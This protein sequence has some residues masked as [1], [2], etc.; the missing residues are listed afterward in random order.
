VNYGCVECHDATVSDN[1]TISSH[2]NH[3]NGSVQVSIALGGT[4]DGSSTCGTN[5][6]CHS[7]GQA[8]PQYYSTPAWGGGSQLD[9]K[10]CHGRYNT[11]D[12][13]SIAGEPN[14]VGGA[15]GSATANSHKTHVTAAGD[16]AK[17]HDGTT[18]N[19][20]EIKDGSTIHTDGSRDVVIAAAWDTNG[21]TSNYNTGNK[22]CQSVAC[23]G[24]GTPQWGGSLT[25]LSCHGG[26]DG[27]T[28]G[29]GSPNGVGA[30]WSSDGHG[31]TS[32]TVSGDSGPLTSARDGCDYCHD[33]GASHTPTAGTNPYR[34][35]FSATDN[36]LC[37]N[38]HLTGDSGISQ[39]SASGSLTT[40]NGNRNVDTA[41][42]GAK[43]EGTEGG[44]LCWDCHDP[45]G[46]PSNILMIKSLVSKNSDQ[47]GIPGTTVTV[48]FTDNS[49]A[50]QAVGRFTELTNNPATGMCQACHDPSGQG[51]SNPTKYWRSDGTDDEDGPGGNAP[52]PSTH[53]KDTLCTTCHKHTDN[54]K[55]A[56]G[57]DCL[58]AGCH[59]GT[60]I[61]NRRRIDTDFGLQSH[62]VGTGGTNMGGAL[63][64][65]D[66]VVCH[67]EGTVVGGQTDT[68]GQPHMDGVIDLRDADSASAYFSYDKESTANGGMPSS[69]SP[70]LWNSTNAEWRNQTSTQLDPFCLTCHDADGAT[71]TF[72]DGS[73]EG[74]GFTGSALNPFADSKITNEYDELDRTRVVNIMDMVADSGTDYNSDG[75][76]D[77][78]D[79]VFARHAIRGAGMAASHNSVY[80]NIP[81]DGSGP[82]TSLWEDTGNSLVDESVTITGEGPLWNDTS[83]MGC[84]DC[85]TSDGANGSAGNA[86]G[87]NSEYL[88]K[89]ASGTATEGTFAARSYIC[90]KCHV[91]ATY[92]DTHTGGSL[93]ND[94][95]DTTANTGL[96]RSYAN[97][98]D[99][100]YTGIAC[101]NCHGGAPG[102]VGTV[103][104]TSAAEATAKGFG[105]IHGTSS[106]FYN[107]AGGNRESYRF[108]NGGSLRYFDPNGWIPS[109]NSSM[110]CYTLGAGSSSEDQWGG[111]TQHD[112][113]KGAA[114]RLNRPKQ[115]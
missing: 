56:G 50:G 33:L 104:D 107:G 67:A 40:R 34:L 115:Y 108:T 53:N 58:S 36:T 110:S 43:H 17:C 105:R 75:I 103:H 5:T 73:S 98:G 83:V 3:V 78:Y 9:C 102:D 76:T 31:N 30:E 10:G 96:D 62:H 85:H 70:G 7:S 19:G 27:G 46:V 52:V 13:A 100:G 82:Y 114:R 48:N 68:A 81:D 106:V 45:H 80:Q 72:N 2:A 64:N 88:L 95:D 42:F 79:G 1:T 84:A 59:G 55:G 97:K 26:P 101:I 8:T 109:G 20:T 44:K 16:C 32:W 112:R 28:L 14:Y 91:E 111:C 77:P 41:H 21:A 22:T 11:P 29:D 99:G 63:T 12:F 113:E 90:Y 24:S 87:S 38:C 60:S 92:D 37:L 71:Q 35:R 69:A 49:T 94:F 47:Y 89:D 74:L 54:F 4:W 39:D 86:H 6:Y 51:S 66:C 65:Y 57:G 61:A 23:H 15:A 25:C 18:V 93:S